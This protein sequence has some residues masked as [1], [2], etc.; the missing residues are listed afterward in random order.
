MTAEEDI[1]VESAA[2]LIVETQAEDKDLALGADRMPGPL[3]GLRI[4][5]ERGPARPIAPL[6]A[7]HRMAE[8]SAAATANMAVATTSNR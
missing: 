1:T 6:T 2:P 3:H 8:P 7:Q 4:L 5:V